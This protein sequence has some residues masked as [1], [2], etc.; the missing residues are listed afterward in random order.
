MIIYGLTI[1]WLNLIYCIGYQMSLC[2]LEVATRIRIIWETILDIPSQSLR[3]E[4]G[5]L[6][7]KISSPGNSLFIEVLDSL[8]IGW[9]TSPLSFHD[10]VFVFLL[11]L[12]FEN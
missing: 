2:K 7:F 4:S 3:N 6:I 5:D 12:C 11:T 10:M 1:V 8:V 9:N